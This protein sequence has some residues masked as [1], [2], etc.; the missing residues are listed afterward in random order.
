MRLT[1]FIEALKLKVILP[2]KEFSVRFTHI[3]HSEALKARKDFRK[4]KAEE[5]KEEAK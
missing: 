1:E 2:P 5:K 3:S 4:Q